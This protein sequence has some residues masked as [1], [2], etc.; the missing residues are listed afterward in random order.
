[1]LV[2]KKL[3][4]DVKF[5]F[6]T[7]ILLSN[8]EGVVIAPIHMHYMLNLKCQQHGS[9]SL[10]QS[11]QELDINVITYADVVKKGKDVS[12]YEVQNEDVALEIALKQQWQRFVTCL[13]LIHT[14]FQICSA[15]FRT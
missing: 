3:P 7:I 4:A 12:Q 14:K 2:R 5:R 8:N 13:L 11:D 1:M 9:P 15:Y 6:Y 10:S